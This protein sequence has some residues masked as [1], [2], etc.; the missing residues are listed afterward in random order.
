[1]SK[2]VRGEEEGLENMDE[3]DEVVVLKEVTMGRIEDVEKLDEL[4]AGGESDGIHEEKVQEGRE[5]VVVVERAVKEMREV[6][7]EGGGETVMSN[8]E[9]TAALVMKYMKKVTPELVK[10]LQEKQ[11]VP[12]VAASLEQVVKA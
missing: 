12:E 3:E 1:M 5:E 10:E 9:L 6:V 4:V 7:E 2:K 11:E 8:D